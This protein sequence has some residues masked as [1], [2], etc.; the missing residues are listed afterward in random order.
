MEKDC[1]V[2][3][4]SIESSSSSASDIGIDLQS[5][6]STNANS[7]QFGKTKDN[8]KEYSECAEKHLADSG[9]VQ[10]SLKDENDYKRAK[11]AQNKGKVLY[12]RP[13]F[14]KTNTALHESKR[15]PKALSSSPINS[16]GC[17]FY[18]Q[19]DPTED[20]QYKTIIT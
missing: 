8:G 20:S 2:Q 7:S 19:A 14:Q 15:T 4:P 5:L 12:G 11:P 1:V 10:Q 17:R 3:I 9:F 16:I 13:Q 6:Q 18:F